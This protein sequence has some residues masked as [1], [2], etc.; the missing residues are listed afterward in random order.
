MKK[1]TQ[2]ELLLALTHIKSNVQFAAIQDQGCGGNIEPDRVVDTMKRMC[3]DIV[4]DI[5]AILALN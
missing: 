1:M 3:N 2:S 4:A 5:D